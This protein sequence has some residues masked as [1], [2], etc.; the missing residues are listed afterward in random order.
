MVSKKV[1]AIYVHPRGQLYQSR[2]RHMEELPTPP[3]EY[4]TYLDAQKAK[5]RLMAHK[6]PGRVFGL[7]YAAS[8]MLSPGRMLCVG[9]RNTHELNTAREFGFIPTGIDLVSTDPSILEMDMHETAFNECEFETI[10]GCH[11]LEHAFDLPKVLAEW[12]RVTKPAGAWVIE[13]PVN[14]QTT[15]V[16]RID[17]KHLDGLREYLKPYA[18]QE[19]FAEDTGT[20][21]RWIGVIGG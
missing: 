2:H 19:L 14:Y 10:F 5:T 1:R 17:V 16:D 6:T 15:D 8:R 20:V 13:M 9:C 11:V 18:S 4:Q 12:A 21:V 3:S 7:L